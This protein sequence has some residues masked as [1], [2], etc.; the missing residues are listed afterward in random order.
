MA[1]AARARGRALAD[2]ALTRWQRRRDTALAWIAALRLQFYP[3]TV[4]TYCLGAFAAA[5]G[6]P[7]ARTPF[8]F[9]L[10]AV[11]LIEASTVFA[12]ELFDYESDRRN[13]N[14]G[15]FNGGSRVLVDGRLDQRALGI[16]AIVTL[17]VGLVLFAPAL[18]ATP[19]TL[20]AAA[21]IGAFAIVAV[22]YTVPPLK[23]SHRGAGELDVA[24]THSI[25]ALLP[26]YLLQGGAWSDPLPWQLAAPLGLAVLP[27]I[28]L[29]GV[30]DCDADLAASKR[31]LVVRLG[32]RN[33]LLLAMVATVASAAS[34]LAFAWTG[35]AGGLFVPVA[36]FAL[37]HAALLVWRLGRHLGSA[38]SL[39][40]IDGLIA[41][42]LLYV[43]WFAVIPFWRLLA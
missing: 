3:L 39:T 40:R 37:P 28:T 19:A 35:V 4:I 43:L 34:A 14:P 36:A 10:L 22:G 38:D 11:L 26:G 33:A 31:T 18:H 24:L 9:G 30:P 23:L 32:R 5:A 2:G 27:S 17:F 42:A 15:P 6:A 16:G 21:A 7:L 25:G 41:L 13:R 29:A 20:Q 1:R 12:N 8:W